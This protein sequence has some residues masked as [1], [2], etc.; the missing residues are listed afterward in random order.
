M[1]AWRWECGEEC[2]DRSTATGVLGQEREDRIMGR[3][4]IPN[5]PSSCSH[6]K[7][8][9]TPQLKNSNIP[10]MMMGMQGQEMGMGASGWEYGE[11]SMEMGVR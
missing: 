4:A 3:S 6:T 7:S 9:T 8:I 1:G 5:L 10:S 2:G 11:R